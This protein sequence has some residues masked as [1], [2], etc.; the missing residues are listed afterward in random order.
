MAVD[1]DAD[2]I[3]FCWC[4]V[5]QVGAQRRDGVEMR[6]IKCVRE[7]DGEAVCVNDAEL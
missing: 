5:E 7:P 1:D 4:C 6:I 2:C 3:V